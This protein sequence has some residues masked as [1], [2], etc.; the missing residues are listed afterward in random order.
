MIEMKISLYDIQ[1]ANLK[2]YATY[3]SLTFGSTQTL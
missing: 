3:E 2:K 1:L